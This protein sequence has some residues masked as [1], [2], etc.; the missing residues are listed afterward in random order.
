MEKIKFERSDALREKIKAAQEAKE[1]ATKRR[2]NIVALNE[3][4]AQELIE[5]RA[6]LEAAVQAVADNPSDKNRQAEA[7]ARAKVARLTLEAAGSEERMR[8]V[9]MSDLTK[10]ST[11]SHAAVQ[12]A[13]EEAQAVI[14]ENLPKLVDEL[15]AA[16]EAYLGALEKIKAMK[17][18]GATFVRYVAHSVGAGAHIVEQVGY[19]YVAPLNLGG[20]QYSNYL[21]ISSHEINKAING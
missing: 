6:E 3:K 21:G 13:K 12:L 16:R 20:P 7:D 2:E 17:R 19:P 9:A 10:D 1:E 11:L 4:V 14:D 5:A 18:D 15:R 8:S